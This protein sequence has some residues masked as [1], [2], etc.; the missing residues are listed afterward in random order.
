MQKTSK[1]SKNYSKQLFKTTIQSTIQTKFHT[2]MEPRQGPRP[3]FDA[4]K[5]TVFMQVLLAQ[6]VTIFASLLRS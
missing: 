1:A 2:T 4:V 5:N 6:D 3:I